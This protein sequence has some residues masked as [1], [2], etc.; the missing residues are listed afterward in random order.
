MRLQS[1]KRAWT[2][3]H[4]AFFLAPCWDG[5]SMPAASGRCLHCPFCRQPGFIKRLDEPEYVGGVLMRWSCRHCGELVRH[6]LML[7]R[8]GS[9]TATDSRGAQAGAGD[10]RIVDGLQAGRVLAVIEALPEHCY[11]WG[12]WVYTD[13]EPRERDNWEAVISLWLMHGLDAAKAPQPEGRGEWLLEQR[14]LAMVLSD[15]RQREMNGTALYTR[16]DIAR[17]LGVDRR[18]LDMRYKWGRRHRA[19]VEALAGLI[20]DALEPVQAVVDEMRAAERAA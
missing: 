3:V 9:I 7:K 13:G 4:S 14:M 1:A 8:R 5:L 18:H 19:V 20:A 11:A 16:A 15:T 2:D 6:P 12:R 17:E 10:L